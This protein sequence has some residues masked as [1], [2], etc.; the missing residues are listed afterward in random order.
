MTKSALPGGLTWPFWLRPLSST[1]LLSW[2]GRGGGCLA[3]AWDMFPAEG[4]GLAMARVTEVEDFFGVPDALWIAF[5]LEVGD[6]RRL[7]VAGRFAGSGGGGLLGSGSSMAHG[8]H[9]LTAVQAAHLGLMWKLAKRITALATMPVMPKTS[10]SGP[11]ATNSNETHQ[12]DLTASWGKRRLGGAQGGEGKSGETHQEAPTRSHCF[13]NG[14]RQTRSLGETVGCSGRQNM[15][16]LPPVIV[17]K[18][19]LTHENIRQPVA[20]PVTSWHHRTSVS[21]MAKTE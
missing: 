2:W 4:A 7:E 11:P 3:G 6:G 5:C 13:E 1:G 8:A 20:S 10:N 16:P 14:A 19:G 9:P 21:D 15:G 17:P 18:S 12:V